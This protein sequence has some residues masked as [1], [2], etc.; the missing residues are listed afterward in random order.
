MKISTKKLFL[1]KKA[2]V[3]IGMI[4]VICL[5]QLTFS[6]FVQSPSAAETASNNFWLWQFFGRLHPLAV[7]FPLGLLLFAAILELVTINNFSSLL[8]PG[9]NLLVITG[10]IASIFSAVLG[11]FIQTR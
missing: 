8:R 1:R 10:V 3:V 7:H 4:G 11:L 9:I 5:L 6:G 2:V